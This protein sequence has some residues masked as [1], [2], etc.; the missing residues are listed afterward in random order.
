MSS[1]FFL[2][3]SGEKAM[4]LSSEECDIIKECF[5]AQFGA[6]DRLW[7]FGSRADDNARGGDIDLYVETESK[8]LQ[9]AFNKK[10]EFILSLNIKLGEQKF[11]V[12]LNILTFKND[13]PIYRIAKETGIQLV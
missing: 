13:Q 4:R 8:T 3:L 11:D 1:R 7:L 2:S 5:R 10:F 12:V 6:N 9:E